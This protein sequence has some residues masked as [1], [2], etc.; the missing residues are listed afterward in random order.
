MLDGQPLQRTCAADTRI[1]FQ[2]AR[3]LPWQ[4]VLDNVTLGLP[5]S[6]RARGLEVLAQVG[7]ADRG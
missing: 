7:L 5:P 1:M 3:L 2:E 6:Q 4:R